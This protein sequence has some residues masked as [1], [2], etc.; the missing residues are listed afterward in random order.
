MAVV[1]DFA[2]LFCAGVLAGTE[3]IVRFGVRAPIATLAEQPQIQLRQALV[4]R[5]RFLVA[6]VFLL[7]TGSGIAVTIVDG[8]APG[9]GFR[10]AA[11]AAIVV[12]AVTT[13]TGTVPINSAIITWQPDAPPATWRTLVGRWERLDTVRALAALAAFGCFLVAA[14]LTCSA[15][16]P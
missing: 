11:L 10:C 5:M 15:R 7:T 9:L 2:N 1:L 13:F 4:Y 3:F 6:T 8:A 14:A 16:L 12:W